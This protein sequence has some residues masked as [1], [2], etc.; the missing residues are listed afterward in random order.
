MVIYFIL[1]FFSMGSSSSWSRVGLLPLLCGGEGLGEMAL[2]ILSLLEFQ[3][4]SM[5]GVVNMCK[6]L[7][8]ISLDYSSHLL[9][10]SFTSLLMEST[11][12]C[13]LYFWPL[14]KETLSSCLE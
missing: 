2:A 7:P 1:I 9:I 3:I 8:I 12:F 13:S 14:R 4:C 5:A 6:K 10:L 11:L